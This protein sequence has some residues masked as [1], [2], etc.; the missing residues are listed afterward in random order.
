MEKFTS[1]VF[2]V[3]LFDVQYII[4]EA[5]RAKRVKWYTYVDLLPGNY[6]NVTKFD[7]M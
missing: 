4:Y 6:L 7:E 5:P 1:T 2:F 3:C